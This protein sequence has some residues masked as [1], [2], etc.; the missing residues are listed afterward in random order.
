MLERLQHG[1]FN[2]NGLT[3]NVKADATGAPVD[4]AAGD[5]G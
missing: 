3:G 2:L 1:D 4:A 5:A